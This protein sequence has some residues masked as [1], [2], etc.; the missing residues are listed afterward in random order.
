MKYVFLFFVLLAHH[1]AFSQQVDKVLMPNTMKKQTVS[2]ITLFDSTRNTKAGYYVL[3]GYHVYINDK[4]VNKIK[5]KR[6]RVTGSV[7]IVLGLN[8]LPKVVDK[9]GIEIRRQGYSNNIQRIL[10]PKIEI[11][12]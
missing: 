5:G 1:I 12:Q 2:F 8:T 4:T 9:K 11:I 6:I 3:N 7:S 10:Y